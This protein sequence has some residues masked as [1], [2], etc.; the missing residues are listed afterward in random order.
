MQCALQFLLCNEQ[1]RIDRQCLLKLGD[2]FV[3][4][5]LLTE[6]LSAVNHHDCR[7]KA[8]PLKGRPV[9]QVSR[10]EVVGLFVE[11]ESRFEVLAG[12]GV[13]TFLV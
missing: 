1:R 12:L 5:T 2:G 11:V 4:L 10:L 8:R 7:F 13:L 6:L 9:T 3:Q